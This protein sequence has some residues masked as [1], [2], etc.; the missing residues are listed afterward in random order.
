M[1]HIIL[2]FNLL[3]F[4][5]I[6]NTN[7]VKAENLETKENFNPN[8][9]ISDIDVLDTTT[10]EEEDI[11][12]FLIDKNSYLANKTF[13]NTYGKSEKI[14]KIIYNASVKNYDCTDITLSKKSDEKE[15]A[16]KCKAITTVNPKFLLVLLQKEQSLIEENIPTQ[17]QLDWAVGY[18]CLDNKK[19]NDRWKGI[20]KQINSA[21]LQFYSYMTE[22]HLY[23]YQK[24]STYTF[25]NPYSD[26]DDS[27]V[28]P[29]NQATAALY[30]YTPHVYNGNYNFY[31]I[32]KKYFTKI[33]PNGSLLQVKGELGVWLIENGEKRPFTS[34]N[35]LTTRFD[36][37]KII[38]ISRSD[39]EAYPKGEAI[40]YAN[41]SLLRS[42]FQDKIVL[43]VDNNY[44]EIENEEVFRQLGFNSEEIIN[45]SWRDIANYKKGKIITA[46]ST[47]ITGVLM[48]DI[49]TGGVYFVKEDTKAP[50][51]DKAFLNIKYK[52][53][54]IIPTNPE[55][56]NNYITINPV[57]FSD[58][59]ILKASD[60]ASVYLISDQ[61]KKPF[62]SGKV[63]VNLGYKWENVVTVSSKV[64]S[65][66]EK[67][68]VIK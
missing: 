39:L 34:R 16:E 15:R 62:A 5:L 42:L 49:K 13:L 40:K 25:T 24:N 8:Y 43:I 53:K 32:W 52:N 57:L 45:T 41:Y 2:I 18:G 27:V 60:S 64:L 3:I 50:I 22:P 4:T 31:K 58:G 36:L 28:T 47:Y 61:K 63:F 12:N 1:K 46:S 56:L 67:G 68:D 7:L 17:N 66:Y 23:T 10:M 14:A 19:C 26:Q 21:A 38:Q 30:N 9:I 33:Y 35:A 29:S 44:R 48:Q 11:R 54:K 51:W 20:G 6:L 37:K 65:L 59:E 55:E